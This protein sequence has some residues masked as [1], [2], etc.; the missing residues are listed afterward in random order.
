M[1][2]SS[3]AM[4]RGRMREVSQPRPTQEL[5]LVGLWLL[6]EERVTE[7]KKSEDH[8][9]SMMDLKLKV[10]GVKSDC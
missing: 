10:G 1:L 9:E 3:W 8:G 7:R 6:A 5:F 2:E 4:M